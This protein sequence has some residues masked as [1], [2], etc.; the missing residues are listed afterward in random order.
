M[1]G[2]GSIGITAVCFFLGAGRD[3]A[4]EVGVSSRRLFGGGGFIAYGVL[5]SGVFG[6]FLLGRGDALDGNSNS[7]ETLR[8]VP[9]SA[10]LQ[11]T[12]NLFSA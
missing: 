8:D 10:K 4:A 5:P 6:M 11:L 9:G 3:A 2:G 12:D 7:P 1:S